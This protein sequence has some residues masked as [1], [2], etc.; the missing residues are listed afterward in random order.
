[1]L[2]E[3]YNPGSQITW[4]VRVKLYI[5]GNKIIAGGKWREREWESEAGSDTWERDSREDPRARK[6]NGNMQLPGVGNSLR[7]PTDPGLERLPGVNVGDL[8]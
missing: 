1:M 8:S 5:L 2:R 6:M 7:S 4:T 3:W